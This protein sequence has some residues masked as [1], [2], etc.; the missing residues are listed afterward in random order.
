M[1]THY[2]I[3]FTLFVCRTTSKLC[4]NCCTDSLTSHIRFNVNIATVHCIS[5]CKQFTLLAWYDVWSLSMESIFCCQRNFATNFMWPIITTDNTIIRSCPSHNH[6]S[7]CVYQSIVLNFILHSNY[8]NAIE[9]NNKS[10]P[11]SLHCSSFLIHNIFFTFIHNICK[12]IKLICHFVCPIS[13]YQTN[14]NR[15][16][17]AEC[18]DQKSHLKQRTFTFPISHVLNDFDV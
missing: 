8:A 1:R 5:N 3:K 7:M 13:L 15:N 6:H 4:T 11:D 14:L 18:L 10:R 16:C 12:L 17:M 2:T 9:S